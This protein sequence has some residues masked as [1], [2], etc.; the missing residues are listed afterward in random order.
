MALAILAIAMAAVMRVI[1]QAVDITA[2]LRDRQIALGVAQDVLVLHYVK[3]DWPSADVH[4][5][6]REQAGRSWRW[7]ER[8]QS[9]PF[10]G[11][12]R[13]EIEVR[14]KDSDYVLANLVSLLRQP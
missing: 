14:S 1:G 6:E 12:R 3:R 2:G 11:I 8:V 7:T 13:V 9:T 4:T 10:P 5:G